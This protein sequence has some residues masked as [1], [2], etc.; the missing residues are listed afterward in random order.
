MEYLKEDSCGGTT[1][2][3]VW[4]QYA[5][6]R[7]GLNAT[8]KTIYFSVTEAVDF[9]DGEFHHDH[10]IATS[11]FLTVQPTVPFPPKRI[12]M[13]HAPRH[14]LRSAINALLRC[15]KCVH[16]HPVGRLRPR[17]QR[18]LQQ[19]SGRGEIEEP[20][21]R[22]FHRGRFRP[23]PHMGHAW[24]T[25]DKIRA[26]RLP[27]G[28]TYTIATYRVPPGVK[29]CAP[30]AYLWLLPPSSRRSLLTHP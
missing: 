6:M 30:I 22:S 29:G 14:P 15:I 13:P 1:E 26:C 16:G 11:V 10:N 12:M 19:L 27:T 21:E 20:G 25:R 8:N 3:S 2:G 17:P 18:S 23:L 9:D 24:R 5:R 28:S 4:D 7:D